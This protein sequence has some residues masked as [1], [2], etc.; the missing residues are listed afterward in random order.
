M[1]LAPGG[2]WHYT[3]SFAST[4]PDFAF[5]AGD[6]ATAIAGTSDTDIW[7]VG[8]QRWHND[9]TGWTQSSM[10][11]PN[12]EPDTSLWSAGNGDYYAAGN[13]SG[14]YHFS[15]GSWNL[16]CL[17]PGYNGNDPNVNQVAGDNN[18]NFYAAT[19]KGLYKRQP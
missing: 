7:A 1:T 12:G 4:T 5:N 13:Y 9:G 15:G 16:E 18:G 2:I 11:P 6:F 17:A 14:L 19:Q 10:P 3:G 8:S